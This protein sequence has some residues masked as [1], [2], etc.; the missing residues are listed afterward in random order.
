MIYM[1]GIIVE[2]CHNI[3]IVP[4]LDRRITS[5]ISHNQ[6]RCKAKQIDDRQPNYHITSLLYGCHSSTQREYCF[7][8]EQN[9][10]KIEMLKV[11]IDYVVASIYRVVA[12]N[13]VWFLLY[14][15]LQ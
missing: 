3:Q 10:W 13:V 2:T 5:A 8:A 11:V 7:C 12:V 9:N 4:H 15:R 1:E 14:N 6:N